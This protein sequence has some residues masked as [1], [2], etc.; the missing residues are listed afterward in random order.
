MTQR[1]MCVCALAFLGAIGKCLAQNQTPPAT[2]Q[3]STQTAPAPAAAPPAPVWS[4]GPIDFSGLIDGYYSLNFNHPASQNNVVRN[5]DVKANQFSLNMAKFSMAHTPD[6]VGFNLELGFGRAFEIFHATDPAGTDIVRHLY[7]A[8]VSVKPASLKGLQIDFGKFAT[9]AGAEVTETHLN[10]NYSRSLL[11][12]LG[13]YYHM[14]LRTSMPIG[15]H[16]TG[17][18][19]V[20]NGWNNVEDNNSGKTVGLTGAFTSSKFNWYN[21]YYV[22]P[23]H[24]NTNKGIRNFYDTVVAINPNA[25]VNFLFNLDVGQDNHIDKGS[26]NF[27]GTSFA[28]KFQLNDSWA[29][30]PRYDYYS[31]KDGWATG[32]NQKLQEFT[33]TGEYKMKEGFLTRLEYRRDWSD[34]PFFDRGNGLANSKSQSTITLGLIAFF[35]PKR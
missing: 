34:R 31:D 26:D 12:A 30:S 9:S 2:D 6:P 1:Q 29:I 16:F 33:L 11:Y 32:T 22:G 23:E 27:W 10:W 20:V 25:K 17:G 18:V 14:G 8:Y 7:Q 15:K 24:N 4:A 13:P 19:Q 5:F 28:T 21:N 35:G 3:S